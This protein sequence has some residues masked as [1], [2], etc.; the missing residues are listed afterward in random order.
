MMC[1]GLSMC[2]KRVRSLPFPIVFCAGLVI[3]ASRLGWSETT[4]DSVNKFSWIPNAGWLNWEG[5]VTN[6]AVF[7]DRYASGFI[8][9]ANIGWFNLGDGSP[10]NEIQYS[11]LS[12][13]DVGVNVDTTSDPDFH[14]LSGYGWSANAG[15]LVFDVATVAGDEHQP[16]IEKQ[17]GILHGSAWCPNLGWLTLNSEGVAMVTTEVRT[18][19]NAADDWEL[20]Q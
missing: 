14:I 1:C 20:Y 7:N 18:T 19:R 5:D 3:C 2:F 12:A 8:Y 10:V 11:N 17:T 6:G 9:G 15:W 13:D 16:R 4:I